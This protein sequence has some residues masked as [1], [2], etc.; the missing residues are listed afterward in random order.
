VVGNGAHWIDDEVNL[1]A[2]VADALTDIPAWIANTGRAVY[3][4]QSIDAELATAES[5][6][7]HVYGARW[8]PDDEEPTSSSTTTSR[9]VA[10]EPDH[11][12]TRGR[13][14]TE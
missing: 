5:L 4:W 11:G 2:L 1:L 10:A 6:T 7:A 8:N 3:T 13:D 9:V 12:Q 14:A